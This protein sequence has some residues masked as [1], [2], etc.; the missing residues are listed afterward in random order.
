[1]KQGKITTMLKPKILVTVN[2]LYDLNLAADGYILGYTKF[3]SF[4]AKRFSFIEIEEISRKK[5]IYLLLNSLIHEDN[6]QIFKKEAD[7]LA[8]LNICFIV[9]DFG[10]LSHL[11]RVIPANR[12]IYN[13][14]TTICNSD[15]LITYNKSFG[16]VTSITDNLSLLEKINLTNS[17]DVLL[18]IYG[19]YP[20]YQS[21]RKVIS[22]YED[23]KNVQINKS[24]NISLKEDTRNDLYPLIEN[25]Y[26][27][28]IFSND[29]VDLTDDLDKLNNAKFFVIDSF[30]S[31]LEK[32]KEILL[33]ARKYYG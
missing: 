14:Y 11:C 9:Q 4:G 21:Y 28:F 26:G 1:M 8:S 10:A 31:S 3:T 2:S 32:T 29:K 7:K 25:E 18:L 22:L 12:I 16:V 20:I 23:Y 27:S 15:D 30:N 5:E 33:K 6:L 24:K 17:G 13:P 19:H